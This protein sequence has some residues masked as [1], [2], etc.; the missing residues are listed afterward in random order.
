MPVDDIYHEYEEITSQ[1]YKKAANQIQSF[2]KHY[3]YKSKSKISN[4]LPK[5]SILS[6]TPDLPIELLSKLTDNQLHDLKRSVK[7]NLVQ[8]DKKFYLDNNHKKPNIHDKSK[9]MSDYNNYNIIKSKL[10]KNKYYLLYLYLFY[11]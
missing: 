10:S 4:S 3:S 5:Y 7:T 11:L 1:I 2:Y 6:L 8:F 9:I